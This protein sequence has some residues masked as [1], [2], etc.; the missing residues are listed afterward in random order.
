ML[1]VVGGRLLWAATQRAPWLDE[2]TTVYFVEQPG[3]FL[4]RYRGDPH[5]FGYYLPGLV[6]S[7]IST[8]IP[9]LRITVLVFFVAAAVG[10]A[11]IAVGPDQRARLRG[12]LVLIIPAT[13]G[14]AVFLAW[15]ADFRMYGALAV[16]SA[17]LA[18]T[19]YVW[20]LEPVVRP[21]SLAALMGLVAM[22][23]SLHVWGLLAAAMYMVGIVVV[24][25]RLRGQ[26]G[27][28]ESR[29]LIGGAL[30]GTALLA[31]SL[32]IGPLKRSIGALA[33]FLPFE[34]RRYGSWLLDG[35]SVHLVVLL[36][37]AALWGI[38]VVITS[39]P[40][41]LVWFDLPAGLLVGLVAALSPWI[42]LVKRYTV[43]MAV[44]LVVLGTLVRLWESSRPLALVLAVVLFANGWWSSGGLS[45]EREAWGTTSQFLVDSAGSTEP[46]PILV[47]PADRE[48]FHTRFMLGDQYELASLDAE[49]V[50]SVA[51]RCDQGWFIA[52]HAYLLTEPDLAEFGSFEV[53]MRRGDVGL[54]G[55]YDFGD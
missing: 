45:S 10:L 41:P 28:A 23:A 46:C 47:Y 24:L 32:L 9:F 51:E 53:L 17:T 55:R 16:T 30:A 27:I 21:G 52:N 44:V 37:F 40:R 48:L 26:I 25:A 20:S 35:L 8:S 15:G 33:E 49:G 38:S 19:A 50:A 39:T 7:Q 18:V 12:Y 54:V 36:A 4:S 22:T 3:Q 43:V 31:F 5:P 2:L 34:G 1:G 42:S 13:L 11:V 6:A 14:S 29:V